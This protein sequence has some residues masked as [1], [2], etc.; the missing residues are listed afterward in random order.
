MTA[1][2]EPTS[3]VSPSQQ[4]KNPHNKSKRKSSQWSD[5]PRRLI[6]V[7]I[8]APFIIFLLSTE[9]TSL[10]F[11]QSVHLLCTIE[12]LQLI[13][14]AAAV[15]VGPS[16]PAR[17]TERLNFVSINVV[18]FPI[19][20]LLISVRGVGTTTDDETNSTCSSNGSDGGSNQI[21]M[22][23]IFSTA[24]FYLSSYLDLARYKSHSISSSPPLNQEYNN[25]K[26][27]VHVMNNEDIT[28]QQTIQNT[29]Y[30]AVHGI[31]YI[32]L[33][34]YF[35]LKLSSISFTH[36]TY[37]LFVIWNTDTGALLA[38]RFSKMLPLPIQ[39]SSSLSSSK[40]SARNDIVGY[41]I[42]KNRYGRFMIQLVKSISPSKSISGFAGG[43]ALGSLTA[44]YLPA[45]MVHMYNSQ[46]GS[47]LSLMRINCLSLLGLL[48]GGDGIKGS[49]HYKYV[50]V[51]QIEDGHI[52]DFGSCF[53]GQQLSLRLGNDDAMMTVFLTRMI[54][55]LLLSFTAIIGDL[56]ESAVKRN[57][58]KK[59]S[60]KLLPG[61]GGILDRFDSTFLVVV[62]YVCCFLPAM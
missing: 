34:F 60:G 41:I 44:I 51:N 2:Q 17:T 16:P 50:D 26:E 3:K 36:T 35:W 54:I 49:E 43:L 18:L 7:S 10:I 47:I 53:I 48:S 37:L 12:W 38:G 25:D 33:P 5:L 32:T 55:G 59:D 62:V 39:S 15:A 56:V 28:V 23:V 27:N 46:I 40:I 8:G 9:L 21:L 42:S 4:Q 29:K 14:S 6:T 13:P 61:H 31:M 52:L 58:G 24:I 22:L 45:I 11:F 19:L 1:V 20:S 30:H 57:A